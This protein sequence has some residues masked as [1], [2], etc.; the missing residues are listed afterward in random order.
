MATANSKWQPIMLILDL[1]SRLE[2]ECGALATIVCG[3]VVRNPEASNCLEQVYVWCQ[4]CFL[5]AQ[6]EDEDE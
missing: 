5:A 6:E 2:C 1:G 4:D 3:T